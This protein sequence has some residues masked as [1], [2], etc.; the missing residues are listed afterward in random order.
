MKVRSLQSESEGED[1]DITVNDPLGAEKT[2]VLIVEV[3]RRDIN[4]VIPE[5]GVASDLFETTVSLTRA[6]CTRS[7]ILRR[8]ARH[9]FSSER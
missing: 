3:S 9:S 6:S 4:E 8:I 2:R 7:N 1:V 5:Q